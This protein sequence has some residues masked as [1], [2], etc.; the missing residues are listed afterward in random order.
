MAVIHGES[1]VTNAIE[2]RVGGEEHALLPALAQE[3]LD[4]VAAVTEG[5]WERGRRLTSLG[6]PPP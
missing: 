6:A 1:R 3:L 2:Q 4:L 5:A